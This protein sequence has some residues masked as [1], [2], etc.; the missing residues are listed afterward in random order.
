MLFHWTGALF[1]SSEIV[2]WS[3]AL[4]LNKSWC[5]RRVC[6]RVCQSLQAKQAFFHKIDGRI[7]EVIPWHPTSSNKIK[8]KIYGF[9]VCGCGSFIGHFFTVHLHSNIGLEWRRVVGYFYDLKLNSKFDSLLPRLQ[10]ICLNATFALWLRLLLLNKYNRAAHIF[11]AWSIC[12]AHGC[13]W[14]Y[15]LLVFF[16]NVLSWFVHFPFHYFLL[17]SSII[18]VMDFIRSHLDAV[19]FEFFLV[20]VREWVWVH[21][22]RL[23]FTSFYFCCC[24]H[25]NRW[26]CG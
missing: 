6:E 5:C 7:P 9:A 20:C 24:V 22:C 15:I 19:V 25:I 21:C 4:I 17:S 2:G 23:L 16:N 8:R 18:L 10:S 14:S 13:F 1:C 11:L 3:F 26:L 12:A